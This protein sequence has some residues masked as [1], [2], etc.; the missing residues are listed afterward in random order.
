MRAQ[1][2]FVFAE[3]VPYIEF[4]QSVI[5]APMT[6]TPKKPLTLRFAEFMMSPSLQQSE[7]TFYLR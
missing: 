7:L 5:S 6:S 4:F 2:S 3:E 1:N